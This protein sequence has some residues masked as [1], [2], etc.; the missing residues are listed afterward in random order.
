MMNLDATY[1]RLVLETASFA[2]EML[3]VRAWKSLSFIRSNEP[4]PLIPCVTHEDK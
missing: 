4:V 3:A 1:G 2:V